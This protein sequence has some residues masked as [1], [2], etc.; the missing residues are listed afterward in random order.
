[1]R[2]TPLK[3]F[4]Q[5]Y[6]NALFLGCF[7]S[8]IVAQS[9]AHPIKER[10]HALM[11]KKQSNLILAADVSTTKELLKIADECGPAICI[12]KIHVDILEDFDHNFLNELKKLSE[13]HEF[14]IMEDRKFADIGHIAR[15]QYESGI[16]R[17][18]DWADIIIC[19]AIAGSD[20]LKELFTAAKNYNAGVLLVA[21]LSS[22]N[23]LIDDMYTQRAYEIAT[24]FD[25]EII[26]FITQR[27]FVDDNRFLFIAP[28]IHNTLNKDTQGQ[29]YHGVSLV[30]EKNGIDL[31]VVGRAILNSP[32][33]G[34]A[35]RQYQIE[36]WS[37]L[38][39]R[40]G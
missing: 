26:G 38:Q 30:I 2:Y 7:I 37:C 19:H 17:I 4:L 13:K 10:L 31:I 16:Y 28:G 25:Q 15:L 1:M 39:L 23:N 11:H 36:A 34:I 3:N 20:S 21:Q 8:N 29:V 12:L 35:A 22:K 6:K 5:I 18:A 14:L 33:P 24:Q 40:N 27:K 9:C 32:N